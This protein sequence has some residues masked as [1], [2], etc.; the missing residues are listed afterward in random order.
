MATVPALLRRELG[1]AFTAVEPGGESANPE[2]VLP[3]HSVLTEH[4]IDEPGQPTRAAPDQVLDLLRT[5]LLE[6][7]QDPVV[8]A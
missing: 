7:D 6:R 3:P 8:N 2:A 4:L 5:R 1:G